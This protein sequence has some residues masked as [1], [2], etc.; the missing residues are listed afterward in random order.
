MD[1]N[2]QEIFET[3]LEEKG[4]FIMNG[5]GDPTDLIIGKILPKHE[6]IVQ[7]LLG[8]VFYIYIKEKAINQKSH[9]IFMNRT[10]FFQPKEW[11]G[12]NKPFSIAYDSFAEAKKA[13]MRHS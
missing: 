5:E 12:T 9:S 10:W 4:F 6:F 8:N 11:I 3:K 13:A 1:E 7:N 2:F